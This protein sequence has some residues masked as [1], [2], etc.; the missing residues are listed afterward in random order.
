MT[1]VACLDTNVL[2][3]AATASELDPRRWAIAHDLLRR[4]S[5]VLPVQALHEFYPVA[6]KKL[7]LD[8]ATAKIWIDRLSLHATVGV[9]AVTV[10]AGI[11]LSQRY[12][13]NYWDGA[14]LAACHRCSADVLYTEDLNHNQVYG[15]V[16]VV[17]PFLQA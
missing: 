16:R 3:Y 11:A 9:D 14:I 12:G 5:I 4:P 1:T 17:N 6:T 8:H 10:I 13:I 2:V 15:S 7:F